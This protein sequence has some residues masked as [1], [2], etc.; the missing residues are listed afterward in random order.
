MND[1][2]VLAAVFVAFVGLWGSVVEA[3]E[4]APGVSYSVGTLV[5]YQGPTYS[6]RQA[7]TSQ[8]SWEP[9]NAPALWLLQSGTPGPTPTPTP[10]PPVARATPTP[11]PTLPGTRPTPPSATPTPSPTPTPG[12]GNIFEMT[13]PA[14]GVTSNTNDGN[15]PGNTVDNNLSTR[16]SG[17][18][19]GA[20]VRYDL[21][22]M[23]ALAQVRVAVHQGNARRNSFD[24]QTSIDGT[25]WSTVF[26]GQSSGTTTA[27]QIYSVTGGARYVRYFGRGAT[28]NAGG[29]T[30]W[31]SVSEVSIY[32]AGDAPPTPTTSPTPTPTSPT[33]ATPTPTPT[34]TSPPSA[35]PTP[36][37]TPT[38]NGSATCAVKSAPSGKVLVGYWESW[39]GSSVHPGMGHIPI[40]Q[41]PSGYNVINTAFPV[42]FSDGTMKWEDGMDVGVDVPTPQEMCAKKAAGHW[43]LMSIGGAAAAIDL[44]QSSVADRFIATA[45]PILRAHNYDGIDIDI[46]AGLVAGPSFGQLSTSQANLIRI[47][48]GI[49]AQ[50]PSNFM[51][52]MAPETAY[53][54]GGQIAYGGPW[55]AYM[56]I[57]KRYLDNGRLNWLQMQYYNGSMYGCNPPG[58]A[59]NAGTVQGFVEQTRCMANGF[60]V[61]GTTVTIPYSKQVPGLPAQPGAGGGY[62]SP[63]LVSQAYGQVSSVKGLM[64]WSINWDGSRGW[65][66]LNSRPF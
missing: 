10:T 26:S 65:T 3:A 9:P 13:P 46:E 31:N 24:L 43:I 56:P 58:Q 36:S 42:I 55:G 16:W 37:P 38:P 12:S 34:P 23:Q 21:G 54:T 2:R 33:N 18:G 6:C 64:T 25:S 35:T 8:V 17:N 39:N 14:S 7:H 47:I 19:T 50:M 40:G 20:W 32:V 29:S 63:S 59:Y 27:E 44:S 57:I 1:R 4:W 49:L 28:L 62:M 52:T 30:T 48:D 51:L 15:V 22:S 45:V 60:T 66:F 5:T 41:V 61:S 11:T 53:V